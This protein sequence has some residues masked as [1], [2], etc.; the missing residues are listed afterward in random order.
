MQP[1]GVVTTPRVGV[2]VP[3][4]ASTT[5]TRAAK[6][7]QSVQP[8]VISTDGRP[9]TGGQ[10]KDTDDVATPLSE[11]QKNS[12]PPEMLESD[13]WESESF[14]GLGQAAQYALVAIGIVGA[15]AGLIATSTYNEGAVEVDFQSYESPE[16]AVAD[17]IQRVNAAAQMQAPTP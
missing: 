4:R 16:K 5:T 11:A 12:L 9:A 1:T 17:A 8:R 14:D 13:P 3:R 15:G 10:R 6:K 7:K 2:V